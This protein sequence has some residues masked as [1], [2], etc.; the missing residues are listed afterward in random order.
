MR[1]QRR[2]KI[3]LAGRSRW[4]KKLKRRDGSSEN[5]HYKFVF[6][7]AGIQGGDACLTDSKMK[8]LAQ[9][10][11]EPL[12]AASAVHDEASSVHARCVITWDLD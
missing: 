12:T 1:Q 11:P 3:S 8:R 9:T 2:R 6:D 4:E 10:W 5:R 7:N